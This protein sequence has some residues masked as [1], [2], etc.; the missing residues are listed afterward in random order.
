M[1]EQGGVWQQ[2]VSGDSGGANEKTDDG[3]SSL[4][5]STLIT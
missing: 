5:L 1:G 2:G 3:W 4:G